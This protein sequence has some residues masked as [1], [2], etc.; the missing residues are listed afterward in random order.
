ME[1][2]HSYSE[3]M[4]LM[5]NSLGKTISKDDIMVLI[6]ALDFMHEKGRSDGYNYV[7]E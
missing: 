5:I 2:Y 6:A 4:N 3:T 1:L 7:G